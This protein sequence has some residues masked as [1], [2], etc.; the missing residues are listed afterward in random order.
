MAKKI[1]GR[2]NFGGNAGDDFTRHQAFE[3]HYILADRTRYIANTIRSQPPD[4][5]QNLFHHWSS[6]EELDPTEAGDW[7]KLLYRLHG[8]LEFSE[9]KIHTNM[10]LKRPELLDLAFISFDLEDPMILSRLRSS[11]DYWP[12][13]H[14]IIIVASG[15]K[16]QAQMAYR[17]P[18]EMHI[19]IVQEIPPHEVI[20]LSSITMLKSIDDVDNV[21]L[22]GRAIG[23]MGK[24]AA[25]YPQVQE[26]MET[27]AAE[28]GIDP[29]QAVM[30]I[31]AYPT[32]NKRRKCGYAWDT[33]RTARVE[34][35]DWDK[36]VRVWL[37]SSECREGELLM[38][39][40]V[41]GSKFTAT[42][43]SELLAD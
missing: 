17:K 16:R 25:P 24:K 14:G 31:A 7:S 39:F 30:I 3:G 26:A 9:L 19:K 28:A 13:D 34:A 33:L 32:P 11:A 12:A 18:G 8:V 1:G 22:G 21:K 37:T 2:G 40:V 43:L 10:M 4:S 41:D 15:K 6:I 36:M 29:K 20:R 35:R 23:C 27:A 38:I 42:P 5:A